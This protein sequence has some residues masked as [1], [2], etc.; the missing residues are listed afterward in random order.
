M[1]YFINFGNYAF[2]LENCPC[3]K[4]KLDTIILLHWGGNFELPTLLCCSHGKHVHALMWLGLGF[5]ME[6]ENLKKTGC[7]VALAI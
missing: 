2:F 6:H 1:L 4:L 7:S 3:M 5:R